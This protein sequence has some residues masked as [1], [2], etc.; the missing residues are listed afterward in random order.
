MWK[1][2]HADDRVPNLPASVP[3]SG[4]TEAPNEMS[5]GPS[6][7]LHLAAPPPQL[8]DEVCTQY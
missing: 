8:H 7:A 1:Q 2:G 4:I 3:P 5:G 6:L